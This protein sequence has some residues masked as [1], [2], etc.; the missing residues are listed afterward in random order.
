MSLQAQSLLDRLIS[1]AVKRMVPSRAP[2]LYAAS[3]ASFTEPVAN[4]EM[5][6]LVSLQF[7]SGSS[8]CQ[9]FSSQ[10]DT[11]L[12][13]GLLSLS[14]GIFRSVTTMVNFFAVFA[15]AA[16]MS[17]SCLGS[18]DRPRHTKSQTPGRLR[19]AA[20]HRTGETMVSRGS[21]SASSLFFQSLVAH[22]VYTSM[23]MSACCH[24]R[25]ANPRRFPDLVRSSTSDNPQLVA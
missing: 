20:A 15:Q 10:A 23:S 9:S 22:A 24:Q 5:L 2:Q 17:S 6:D 4:A 13:V 19:T 1:F 18:Y 3:A 11:A 14:R 7:S 8:S 12:A 16:L 21:S 25:R